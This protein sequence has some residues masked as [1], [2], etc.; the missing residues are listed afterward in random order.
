MT[1]MIATVTIAALCLGFGEAAADQRAAD[2]RRTARAM[3]K[4]ALVLPRAWSLP[5]PANARQNTSG[6][7][8]DSVWNGALIGA[9]IGAAGGLLWSRAACG[10]D[11]EEC[12]FYTGLVGIPVGIGIGAAAGAIADAMR[13]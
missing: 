4:P 2:S 3:Q 8:R 7:R 10:W 13:R 12:S 5:P 11:D 9:G 6:E 1:R